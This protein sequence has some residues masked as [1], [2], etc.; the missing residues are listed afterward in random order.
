V[1][2]HT[3]RVTAVC[4]ASDER[5]VCTASTDSTARVWDAATGQC[6][7]VLQGHQQHIPAMALTPDGRVLATV[8]GDGMIRCVRIH[9]CFQ[10]PEVLRS[11]EGGESG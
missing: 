11:E 7:H 6:R 2:G 4:F 8:S 1:Q 5:V 3:G 9:P 10:T